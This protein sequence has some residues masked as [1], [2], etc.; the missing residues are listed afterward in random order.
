MGKTIE[1]RADLDNDTIV[2]GFFIG[3]QPDPIM[4]ALLGTHLIPTPYRLRSRETADQ[5]SR[6]ISR[7]NPDYRVIRINL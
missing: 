1:L 5:A 6:E 7:S 4:T 3:G 2:A